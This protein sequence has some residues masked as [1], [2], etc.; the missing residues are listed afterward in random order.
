LIDSDGDVA[1]KRPSYPQCMVRI[2]SGAS[3]KELRE[4]IIRYF[5]CGSYIADSE[6][7]AKKWG[8]MVIG[9]RVQF[10]VSPKN[11]EIIER[12]ILPYLSIK[13]KREKIKKYIKLR[14]TKT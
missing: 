3:Q 12:F 5:K 14:R 11:F 1:T 2:T 6:Y 4:L 13:R 7:F 9:K 10:Y 8:V